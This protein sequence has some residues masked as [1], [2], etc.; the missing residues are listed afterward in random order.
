MIKGPGAGLNG[1]QES[2]ITAS[3]LGFQTSCKPFSAPRWLKVFPS[4]DSAEER[5]R[6]AWHLGSCIRECLCGCLSSLKWLLRHFGVS[7]EDERL[8]CQLCGTQREGTAQGVLPSSGTAVASQ[9]T[10]FQKKSKINL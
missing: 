1:S 7:V 8:K 9:R 6:L 3:K 4:P 2:S 10:G 5:R